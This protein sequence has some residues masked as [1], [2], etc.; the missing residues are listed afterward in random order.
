[1][2]KIEIKPIGE[3]IKLLKLLFGVCDEHGRGKV[4]YVA[5]NKVS[6]KL[7]YYDTEECAIKNS[8][9]DDQIYKL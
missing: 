6:R 8:N 7:Y 4:S 2:P 1:M 3:L 5:F 9:S